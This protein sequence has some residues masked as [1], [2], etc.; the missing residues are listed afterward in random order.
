MAGREG[1]QLRSSGFAAYERTR[2]A[3]TTAVAAWQKG[4]EVSIT[5]ALKEIVEFRVHRPYVAVWAEDTTGKLV[6]NISVWAQK[7]RYLPELRTWWNRNGGSPQVESM[8]QPTRPPGRYRIAW[9]GLDDK[10]QPVPPGTYRITVETNREHGVYVKESGSI[11]CDVKAAKITLKGTG[12]FE[13]ITVEY[14]PRS[15]NA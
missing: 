6:R 2:V 11:E 9:D 5:L 3:P 14:G 7:P 1:N 15:Q 10:G 13:D 4:Y 8:T 12:E